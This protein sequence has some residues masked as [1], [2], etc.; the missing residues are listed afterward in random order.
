MNNYNTLI[1]KL[2]NRQFNKL[3]SDIKTVIQV[4]FNVKLPNSQLGKLKP[5]I[6]N[7]IQ[8]SFIKC[9]S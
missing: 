9:R 2:S 8:V 3:K 4:N 1:V 7:G 5:E 6:I